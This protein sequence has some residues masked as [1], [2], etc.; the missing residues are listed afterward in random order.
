MPLITEDGSGRADADSF[1]SLAVA[2][3][4]HVTRGN[5]S[6]A[7][8]MMADKEAALRRST[9]YMEQEYRTKWRGARLSL[10]Q[11][12][13]WPRLNVQLDD[14]GYGRISAY[15]PPNTVP[16][17]V[18]QACCELAFR[19][20]SGPLAPDLERQ[21]IAKTIGPIRTEYAAGSPEYVRFRA[22]DLLLK[23]LLSSGG[24][25]ARLVRA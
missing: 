12:L 17:Q 9:D 8:T 18:S 22:I 5:V 4:Y 11:A 2:D 1:A 3:A 19:A 13:A 20:L 25:G 21:V 6:W 7:G 23:P 24:L 14:V 10:A 15:V 16:V